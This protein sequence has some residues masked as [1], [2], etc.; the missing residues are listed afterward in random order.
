MLLFSEFFSLIFMLLKKNMYT[1]SSYMQHI[2]F[3]SCSITMILNAAALWINVSFQKMKFHNTREFKKTRRNL[4]SYCPREDLHARGYVY[5]GMFK[6]GLGEASFQ[7]FK[8]RT[9]INDH[10][11]FSFQAA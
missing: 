6:K 3:S 8:T 1:H 7:C 5:W 11:T 4:Y 10:K 9:I 2:K